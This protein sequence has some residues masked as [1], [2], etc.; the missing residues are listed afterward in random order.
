MFF[1][2]L[3]E[4]LM[5]PLHKMSYFHNEKTQENSFPSYIFLAIFFF[6]LH[7][8]FFLKRAGNIRKNWQTCN[9]VSASKLV[10]KLKWTMNTQGTHKLFSMDSMGFESACM[11]T[12][13]APAPSRGP[14]SKPGDLGAKGVVSGPG[15]LLLTDCLELLGGMYYYLT[16]QQKCQLSCWKGPISTDTGT[17][18]SPWTRPFG[19]ALRAGLVVP[20]SSWWRK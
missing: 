6:A 5:F 11:R 20:S 4:K 18:S 3:E 9:S 14:S 1:S 19:I 15:D 10:W 2:P 17:P 16:S 8:F 13:S 7:F 12:W